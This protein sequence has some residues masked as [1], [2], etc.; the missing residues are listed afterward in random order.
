MSAQ[1]GAGT[2]TLSVAA[3]TT[4]ALSNT[5][6][7]TPS[8]AVA[9]FQGQARLTVAGGGTLNSPWAIVAGTAGGTGVLTVDGTGTRWNNANAAFVGGTGT[10]A[11]GQGTLARHQRRV[12]HRVRAADG[13]QRPVG[14]PAPTPCPWGRPRP[15]PA[16]PPAG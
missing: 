4:F 13:V 12:R 16:S 2:L 8:L 11:G 15:G 9:E 7:G 10:A 5:A 14:R 3:G 1:T 6:L